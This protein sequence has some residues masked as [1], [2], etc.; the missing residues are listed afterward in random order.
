MLLQNLVTLRR[1][2]RTLQSTVTTITVNSV[3]DVVRQLASRLIVLVDPYFLIA[4]SEQQVD[5]SRETSHPKSKGLEAVFKQCRPLVRE[6]RPASI[7]IRILRDKGK[8]QVACQIHKLLKFS[9]SPLS[10]WSNYPSPRPF[11]CRYSSSSNPFFFLILSLFKADRAHL[12]SANATIA[13]VQATLLETAL[14]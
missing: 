10:I 2:K 12:A 7:G 1:I 14:I 4:V 9:A 11:P 3:L 8:K 6:P 13:R 5:V